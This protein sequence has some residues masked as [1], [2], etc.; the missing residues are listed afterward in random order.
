MKMNEILKSLKE[1]SLKKLDFGAIDDLTQESFVE[2]SPYLTSNTSVTELVLRNLKI[3]PQ[4][5]MALVNA[6]KIHQSVA[7]LHLEKVTLDVESITIFNEIFKINPS[8][9]D[10]RIIN[11]NLSGEKL[12]VLASCLKYLNARR[13]RIRNLVLDDNSMTD[14]DLET[15]AS[16][17]AYNRYLC[18]LSLRN[19]QIT[20]KGVRYLMEVLAPAKPVYSYGGVAFL[21]ALDLSDNLLTQ[22]AV[23]EFESVIKKNPVLTKVEFGQ[24]NIPN[25]DELGIALKS[26]EQHLERN[27]KSRARFLDLDRDFLRMNLKLN[28]ENSAEVYRKSEDLSKWVVKTTTTYVFQEERVAMFAEVYAAQFMRHFIPCYPVVEL[29][30]AGGSF[31]VACKFIDNLFVSKDSPVSL[32]KPMINLELSYVLSVW[33][34]DPD[35][36]KNVFYTDAKDQISWYKL[37]VGQAFSFPLDEP[38]ASNYSQEKICIENLMP[39]AISSLMSVNSSQINK[40]AI[41]ASIKKIIELKPE[42]LQ[43]IGAVYREMMGTWANTLLARLQERQEAF[44]K[45]LPELEEK[46]GVANQI[47]ISSFLATSGITLFST[48]NQ[49]QILNHNSNMPNT[50]NPANDVPSLEQ[51]YH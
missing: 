27:R 14:N 9:G 46:L 37:D 18:V 8:I 44:R 43:Q 11:S 2:I 48:A 25:S 39:K 28:G 1:N 36:E 21:T 6:I 45:I 47:T 4:E 23:V 24:K 15:I 35:I 50:V 51:K 38:N 29:I 32:S 10:L 40:K 33:L 34:G 13:G 42:E 26:I 30:N 19:N 7:I 17:L 41:I 20:D 49:T 22:N 5:M 16:I 31:R 3:M 12:K